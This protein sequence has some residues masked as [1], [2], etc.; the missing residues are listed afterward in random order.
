MNL[1]GYMNEETI[2][3]IDKKD[4]NSIIED[5][6][7]VAEQAGNISDGK[8]FAQSV[9]EREKI[10]STGIGL[11]VAIP[12]FKMKDIPGFFIV[13]GIL[14]NEV[15]WDSIDQKPVK[16]VFLIGGHESQ[17]T[18]YLQIL[19]KLTLFV[20]NDERRKKL[21]NSKDKALILSLFDR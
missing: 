13:L 3:F 21:F 16:A 11:G 6:S 1:S 8:A 4:K 20:K 2:V 17:Q 9:I 12:H 18:K 15:D 14:K 5:L 10:C 19:A 7:S